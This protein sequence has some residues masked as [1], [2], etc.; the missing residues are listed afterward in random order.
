MCWTP[1]RPAPVCYV[2]G[3]PTRP[4]PLDVTALLD[5]AR[6]GDDAAVDALLPLVYDEL[7]ALAGGQLRGERS[8]HTLTP[9][10]LVHEAYLKLVGQHAPW[11][12]RAH[13]FG[14]AALAMRRVLVHHARRR[15]AG[16]RGGGLAAVTL[17]EDGVARET[18]A[19]EVLALDEALDRLAA[20]AERPARVVELRYYGGLT[21]QETAEVLGV[22]VPTVKRDWQT[23]RAWLGAALADDP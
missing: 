2:G 17:H 15:A 14:I 13:F 1:R 21:H 19:D 12:N 8:D 22:S 11:Q 4:S 10:A 23:A 16:K 18:P 6:A 5:G 3:V 7:R 9:T 20:I